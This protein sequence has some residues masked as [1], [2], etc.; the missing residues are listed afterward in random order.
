MNNN[1][2]ENINNIFEIIKAF[3]MNNLFLKETIKFDL[4]LFQEINKY[5]T[6]NIKKL[7]KSFKYEEIY[8]VNKKPFEE[9][10]H[11]INY[12]N[13]RTM[14]E[15][16]LEDDKIKEKMKDFCLNNPSLNIQEFLKGIEY[17]YT[18]ELIN[19]IILNNLD[20]IFINEEILKLLGVPY[21]NYKDKKI[22]FSKIDSSFL[23][24]Y[25]PKENNSLLINLKLIFNKDKKDDYNIQ[26][27]KSYIN[28]KKIKIEKDFN[29]LKYINDDIIEGIILCFSQCCKIKNMYLKHIEKEEELKEYYL[30]NKNWI[31]KIYNNIDNCKEIYNYL[32]QNYPQINDTKY[33]Y[34]SLNNIINDLSNKN[35][36]KS[37]NIIVDFNRIKSD[38]LYPFFKESHIYSKK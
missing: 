3:Y 34:D 33:F 28:H 12:Y 13:F 26:E 6:N 20:V 17:Y 27:S 37:N 5:K 19:K 30:I 4:D 22:Y 38:D 8:I 24:L 2:D 35:I 14:I 32:I 18:E 9:L 16:Q 21:K 25:F 1:E 36:I 29:K 15:K 11:K 31:N 7:I 23:L 10:L